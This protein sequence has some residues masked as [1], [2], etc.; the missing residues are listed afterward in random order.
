MFKASRVWH[1]SLEIEHTQVIPMCFV[2]THS[3]VC[4]LSQWIK[5]REGELRINLLQNLLLKL[6]CLMDFTSA[7]AMAEVGFLYLR[8]TSS[9]SRGLSIDVLILL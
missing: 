4:C 7:F 9:N 5:Y 3:A 6:T 8:G 2:R 1:R